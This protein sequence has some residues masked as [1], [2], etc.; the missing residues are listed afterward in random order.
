MA[1]MYRK[2]LF[3]PPKSSFFLFG[4]RGTGKTQWLSHQFESAHVR[5]DFLDEDLLLRFLSEPASF[6]RALDQVPP[7]KWVVLDEIQK[8]P[9]LLSYVHKAIEERKLKF[10]LC[11]SSARQLKRK[12][13]NLLGGRASERYFHPFLPQELK[14]SFDLTKNLEVGSLPLVWNAE[15]PVERLKAYV[16]VYIRQEIQAEAAVRRLPSFIRFLPVVA[17]FHGQTLSASSLARD[18]G[19]ARTTI[20]GYLDVLMQTLMIFQLEAFTARLRVKEVKH[21][22]LYWFDSGVVRALKKN[23]GLV[24]PE[25]RG[26]LFEGWVAQ[27]LRATHDYLGLYDDWFYWSTHSG[28][29][30]SV[31]VDFLL[32]RGKEW[33]AIEAKASQ[34]YK[35]ELLRGLEAIGELKGIKRRILVYQG[36]ESFRTKNGIEVVTPT[37]FIEMIGRL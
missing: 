21:P 2:R 24:H 5:F 14:E 9:Q 28:G 37:R 6:S 3:S 19:V 1:D 25:E 11:G 32:K 22:K 30:G 8:A 18:S 23:F 10:V 17:L 7:S 26:A 12:G 27:T 36:D 29:G 31:E 20:H 33:I 15:D 34:K 16:Q 13:V 4:P 35:P